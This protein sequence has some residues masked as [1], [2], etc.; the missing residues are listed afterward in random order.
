MTIMAGRWSWTV[1]LP[2]FAFLQLVPIVSTLKYDPDQVSWN[3][4]TNQAATSPLEYSGN[5]TGHQYTASPTNWRFPYYTLMLDK[6]IN[7][8]PTN[9]DA[10]GT[11]F[12]HDLTSTQLR[13]GGDITGLISALDYIQG[14]GVKVSLTELSEKDWI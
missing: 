13:N 5:W 14:M 3:L 11:L 1:L 9:D 6:F 2:L 7:G 4:N 12:E 8:D 10:N